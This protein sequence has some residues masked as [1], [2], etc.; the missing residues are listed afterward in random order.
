[1]S[2]KKTATVVCHARFLDLAS[3][4]E[5][6]DQAG[7]VTRYYDAGQDDLPVA[8]DCN[9]LITLGGPVGAYELADYPW[10]EAEAALL[11]RHLNAGRP[12]LAIC[13]GAQILA[14]TLGAKVFSSVKEVGWAPIELTRE[15]HSSILSQTGSQKTPVLHWHGDTFDLPSGATR[16]ASTAHCENQ[17]FS[18]GSALAVQFHPEVRARDFERW[19]ICNTGQIAAMPGHSVQS[20]REQ[21]RLHADA[22]ARVGQ[23]WFAR[24]LNQA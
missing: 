3:F 16:L 15:G 24:W 14:Q 9:V 18:F 7:F 2:A 23:E 12:L 6:L 5:V 8:D 17:A 22:A 21:A 19:L 1:M 4:A 11:R 10:I 20:L 13:L